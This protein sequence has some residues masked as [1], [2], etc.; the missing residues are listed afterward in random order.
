MRQFHSLTIAGI[1]PEISG[2]ATSVSFTV[3]PEL[4]ST[5]RWQAGQHL[6]LRFTIDG[7]EHRRCYSISNPPGAPLRITAKRVKGGAVSNHIADSLAPGST[8]EVMPPAGRFVLP[9]APLARRTHYFFAAG[10]GITPLF[11]MIHQVLAQEP[12]SAAHLIYGN[13]SAGSILFREEL[14]ALATA[15]PDRFTLRHVLSSP[16]LWSW[17]SP[18]RSGRIT[19]EVISDAFAEVPPVAQD[20]QYWICG[21]G[22]MNAGLRS[23]LMGLDVPPARIHM[24]SFGGSTRAGEGDGTGIAATASVTL[25]GRSQP[26]QVSPGQTLLDAALAAGLEPP[27]SCQSGVCGSCKARL[28]AGRVRMRAQMALEDGEADQGLILTCQSLAET[29]EISFQFSS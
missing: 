24:E 23:A 2:A 9:P 7:K 20:V 8:V 17:F 16:S 19:S 18:W 3:P 12:H 26:V 21:P 5:F 25:N 10:S 1:R 15:H 6:L 11:A 14:E 28:T 22:A 13:A 4:E 27:H 29:E